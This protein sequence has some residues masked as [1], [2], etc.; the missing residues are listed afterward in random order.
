MSPYMSPYISHHICHHRSAIDRLLNGGCTLLMVDIDKPFDL[1][2]LCQAMIMCKNL[3]V[4]SSKPSEI[5]SQSFLAL[6]KDT[7]EQHTD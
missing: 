4:A 2:L 3:D 5:G 1:G 7:N 6:E